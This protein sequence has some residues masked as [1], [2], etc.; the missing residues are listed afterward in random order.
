MVGTKV[1][2]DVGG[3]FTDIVLLVDGELTT[4]KVPSTADQSEGVL[5]GIQKACTKAG[6]SPTTID[7]FSHAMTV[8]TNALLE[9]T[10][11]NTALITTDG[12]RDILEIGR[13]TRPKLY[14]LD[15]EKSPPLVSRHNRLE[16]TERTG[17]DGVRTPVDDD[18]IDALIE[19]LQ[20]RDIESVAISL[21]HSYIDSVNETK[22]ADRLRN[23]T[24][25][26]ISA[27]H[28]VL[29]EFREY[30]RTSTTVVDA[31]VTPAIDSYIQR[32]EERAEATGLP[33]PQIMQSNGGIADAA[34]IREHAV[35][36]ALSGPAAGVV[37][38]RRTATPVADDL[39]LAGLVTFD[40]GGTSSDV[41]LVR[42]GAVERTTSS[43]INGYPIC[44]P[45]VDVT[46]VGSGGGSIAWVDAGGALRVGPESAG[47]EPGPACYGRGGEHPTV[48]DAN[49]LLGYLSE[50]TN[51]GGELK[52]DKQAATDALGRLAAEADLGSAFEAAKGVFRIANANMARAIRSVTV[53]RGHDPREFG[54][55]AFGGAGPMHAAALA[56]SLDVGT[57]VVPLAGGVLSA[58]G[59]LDADEKYDAVQT[60]RTYLADTTPA[61][62]EAMYDALCDEVPV[63]VSHGDVTVSRSA[64]LRYRGQSFELQIPVDES[65][66]IESLCSRFKD[67]H[68]RVYGYTAA[69]PVE[70]VNLRV[71]AS[72]P[73]SA[74]AT[75][76]TGGD[77]VQTSEHVAVFSGDR[78]DTP[79]YDRRTI[80]AGVQFS[81]PA[82]LE[83]DES[84][85]VVPPEWDG[86]IR[87]DGT[88]VLT[89]GNQ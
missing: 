59:L 4:A 37:G 20:E 43:E 2:V 75:D 39:E 1:G 81:G 28:E 80:P 66:S 35:Q 10:G 47:S 34:S 76:F 32:L 71:T 49:L 38:A 61:K 50:D 89:E 77:F 41:S 11:A 70:L 74:P 88:L 8:S 13:Q 69:E 62:L 65:V 57:V 85:T 5:E 6:I 14:D 3:T 16:V 64:D 55:V 87:T 73:R 46:T 26:S 29:N 23:A 30:E 45:M 52:L 53:E 19:E 18:E 42:D 27:S 31:Y 36:T 86:T 58:Y 21:L 83:Q 15:I 78:Y 40:M 12:F 25:Y 7:E 56:D 63:S 51:L 54:I 79:V 9:E 44:V 82:I 60:Y 68:E 22:I 67:E 84:T 33:A 24:D 72:I 17:V 48:T